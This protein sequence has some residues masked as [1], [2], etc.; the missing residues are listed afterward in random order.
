MGQPGAE[1]HVYA[2]LGG[3]IE[4]RQLRAV[5]PSSPGEGGAG[6]SAEGSSRAGRE[7][8]AAQRPGETSVRQTF[9]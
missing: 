4:Q 1:V 7:G 9:S 8:P 6:E 5:P 3:E 2:V